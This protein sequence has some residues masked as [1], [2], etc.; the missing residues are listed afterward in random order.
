MNTTRRQFLGRALAA[1]AVWAVGASVPA[2]LRRAAAFES[3]AHDG[4][5]L[6]IVQL[7]GGNDGLN[8]IVPFRHDAYRKARPTLAQPEA[9][10]LRIN[11]ELALHPALKGFASLLEAGRL[12]I[13]QGVGYP[14]P[15]RSHFESMDIW[16]T[17]QRK[18]DPRTDGWIGRYLDRLPENADL[19]A[20]HLGSEKQP[21][22]LAARRVRVP[23]VKSLEQFRLR[24]G[25][26]QTKQAVD[27]LAQ[28][29][30]DD[31][32]ELL[33]FVQT[34]TT[35]ALAVSERFAKLNSGRKPARD[36]PATDLGRKLG[37]VAQL[38]AAAL[39]TRVY[40]VELDGFDTHA[41]QAQA[42]A[43]LLRQL[44]EAVGAFH[45]D[46]QQQ[47]LADRV[48]L[49][50][51]S[52]FGRRLAENASKGT[53]HGAAAPMFLVGPSV[54]AGLVGEH[55]SL[56]QLDEGDLIHHTDF[57]Q[58]YATVL[59]QWLKVQSE[60]IVGGRFQP[61]PALKGRGAA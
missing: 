52:E 53:D 54:M 46:M 33:G 8:T 1:P 17:C 40:Y 39:P 3:G 13:I 24:A 34:S 47:G 55:P 59:E 29:K 38:I 9:D 28:V 22:A 7:S 30:R 16:H 44:G 56:L 19:G 41:Q 12:A 57:R 18:N 4:R 2:F 42:H 31:S 21:A 37:T 11:D 20:M 26:D 15:N 60:P 35:S 6:V 58:V 25:T 61:V 48:L 51:F 32:D 27:A 49:M 10:V 36:Y 23:S 14:N 43:A 45:D 5:V 50:C